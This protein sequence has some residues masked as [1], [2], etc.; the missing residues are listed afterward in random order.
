[1]GDAINR[2]YDKFQKELK[3]REKKIKIMMKFKTDPAI[4]IALDE[5]NNKEFIFN[6]INQAV[7]KGA[8]FFISKIRLPVFV[9]TG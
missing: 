3:E 9:Q 1:M 4:D 6:S 7:P 5:L 2:E 8:A